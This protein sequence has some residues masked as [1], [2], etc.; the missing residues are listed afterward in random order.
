MNYDKEKPLR[1][2][3]YQDLYPPHWQH[4]GTELK[5]NDSNYGNT[6]HCNEDVT[7]RTVSDI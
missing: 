7:D 2:Q 3:I 6:R 1:L 5:N 4:R